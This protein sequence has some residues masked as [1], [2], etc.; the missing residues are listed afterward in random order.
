M[1]GLFSFILSL[2]NRIAKLALYSLLILLLVALAWTAMQLASISRDGE[3]T[4]ATFEARRGS[5]SGTA[6][7][8]SGDE[9]NA[10]K[11]TL[12]MR[13]L[14]RQPLQKAS[15]KHRR[16]MISICPNSWCR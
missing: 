11:M 2:L 3:Y 1:G 5:Y 7:A 13:P 9:A 14:H 15:L 6:T 8:I 12:P 4:Q 10:S 16:P